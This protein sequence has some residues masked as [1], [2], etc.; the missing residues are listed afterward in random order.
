MEALKG[1][2]YQQEMSPSEFHFLIEAL[3]PGFPKS[4][5]LHAATS[6]DEHLKGV[7]LSSDSKYKLASLCRA[8]YCH[9]LYDEWLKVVE[10][11]FK[12]DGGKNHIMESGKI[13]SAMEDFNRNLPKSLHQPSLSAINNVLYMH[14]SVGRGSHEMSFDKFRREVFSNVSINAELTVIANMGKTLVA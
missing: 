9:I 3:C 7:L 2:D 5:I 14:D 12:N 4:L 13:K 10:E 1:F 11:L 8:V 6:T